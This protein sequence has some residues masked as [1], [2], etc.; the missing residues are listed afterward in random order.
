[1]GISRCN[2]EKKE[3]SSNVSNKGRENKIE[4]E[5][6]KYDEPKDN[7]INNTENINLDSMAQNANQD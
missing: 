7:N 5:D 6:E 3:I 1:M 2:E 4:K